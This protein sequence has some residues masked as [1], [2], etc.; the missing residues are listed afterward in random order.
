MKTF[1]INDYEMSLGQNAKENDDLVKST[2]PT[3]VWLHLDK[4]SSGHL[5][6]HSSD[7]PE[8][9]L[10]LAA[11]FCWHN[12]KFKNLPCV[13]IVTTKVSNLQQTDV[14]GEVIFRSNRKTQ[15]FVIPR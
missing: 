14:E 9:I 10:H 7:V 3:H 2:H 6:I 8:Y 1:K 4:Y 11:H 13:R 15:T 5:V 12:T